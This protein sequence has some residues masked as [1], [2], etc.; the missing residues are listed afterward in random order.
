MK[1]IFFVSSILIFAII[2]WWITQ[3]NND[4]HLQEILKAPS[5]ENGSFKDFVYEKGKGEIGIYSF[6]VKGTEYKNGKTDG[7][8][9]K[10]YDSLYC[11]SFPV[12]YNVQDPTKN[13][14]LIFP[15]DFAKFNLPYPDSLSWVKKIIE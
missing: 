11:K 5:F 12:I 13:R 10:I 15:S 3:K 8:L 1:K 2:M 6:K 14:I 4:Q 7:R 9:R